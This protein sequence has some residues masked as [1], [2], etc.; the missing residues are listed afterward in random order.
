MPLFLGFCLVCGVVRVFRQ[1]IVDGFE[2]N[3]NV[4]KREVPFQ[5][6]HVLV[7]PAVS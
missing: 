3:C 6:L 5:A 2:S 1:P 7:A 4:C